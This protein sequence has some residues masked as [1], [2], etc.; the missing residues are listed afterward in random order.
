MT[1]EVEHMTGPPRPRRSP[2]SRRCRRLPSGR[3]GLPCRA[4]IGDGGGG[5]RRRQ[6]RG[7]G[8]IRQATIRMGPHDKPQSMCP[9]FGS[10]RVG[11][12][13]RRVA[14][15]LSGSAC[16]VYG[17]TFVS[18]FLRGAPLGRLCAVQFRDAGDRQAV[19]GHPRRGPR[20]G[21]SGAIRRHR[22]D[23]PLRADGLGRAAAAAARRDQRR[24]DHRHRRAGFGVPTHAE[25]K[26]VLAGCDAG[27]CA[28]RKPR[29][30]PSRRPRAD[31]MTGRR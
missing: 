30:G 18:A 28:H 6:V 14:T 9:A 21:G 29:Q 19:R 24:A 12:R 3:H 7:A 15:V 4:R 2:G 8:P 27:L 1:D 20:A 17:L 5:A 16:C 11:L 13:M 22:R 26:D 25:A 23:Q 31:A 10:L